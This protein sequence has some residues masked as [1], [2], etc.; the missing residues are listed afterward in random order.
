MAYLPQHI[1]NVLQEAAACGRAI[2]TSDVPGCRDAVKDGVT[3]LLVKPKDPNVLAEKIEY[4][5]SINHLL[6]QMGKEARKLAEKEYSI[7][8]V[9]KIHLKIYKSFNE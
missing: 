2:I 9:I 8:E 5:L 4:L 6:D 3:G 1:G 7:D